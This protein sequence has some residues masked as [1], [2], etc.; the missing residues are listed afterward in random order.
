[1]F[2]LTYV[3]FLFKKQASLAV[4]L[5][6]YSGGALLR[7]QWNTGNHARFLKPS[8]V[9]PSKIRELLRLYHERVVLDYF[10]ISI[11]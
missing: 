2:L 5:Y 4:T 1:M 8:S 3:D 9:R 11:Q 7:S 6:T 10:Q